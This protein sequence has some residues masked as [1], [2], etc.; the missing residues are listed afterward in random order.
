MLLTVCF[1]GGDNVIR[2]LIISLMSLRSIVMTKKERVIAAIK[3]EPVDHVPCG[4]S[5]HFPAQEAFG[6]EGV[7]SHLRFFSETDTDICKIMNEHLVPSFGPFVSAQ[8]YEKVP[9]LSLQDDFMQQQL[10]LTK[11]IME[12]VDPNVFT[13]ATLHGILAS[14]IHPL[15][16]SGMSYEQAR[17]FLVSALREN[18][19]PVLSAMHRIASCMCSLAKA[20]AALGVD[21]VY[22]AALGA[23]RHY[24]TDEEFEAWILPF[25]RQI[26]S[27]IKKAN[28]YSFLHMC[29]ENLDLSRYVP[30]LDLVDVVNWG[31]YEVPFSLEAGT[32]L[33]K[34]K[35]ILGGLA[36]RS[37]SLFEGPTSQ[38]T[39][40][41]QN[42]LK[43]MGSIGFILGADCTL[44]TAQDRG[45]IRTAVEA[46]RTPH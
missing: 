42:V 36:N 35:T 2:I 25:D 38:L 1:K 11:K 17:T 23:E 27:A 21:G 16:Q 30:L 33:F 34:G 10:M 14:A 32:S 15:E 3:K 12:K 9:A 4:F 46:C 6:D 40:D 8:D 44:D 22:Y 28:A 41:I 13:V 39:Q 20:Y 26:L 31:I 7:S 29:K 45:L 37:G 19:E 43:Q 24:F 18:P 5:L